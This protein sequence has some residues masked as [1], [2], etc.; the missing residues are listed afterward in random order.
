MERKKNED[1]LFSCNANTTKK[2][3]KRTKK[4]NLCDK[5]L[6]EYHSSFENKNY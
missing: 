3:N 5:I 6:V 2:G 1:L 4:K